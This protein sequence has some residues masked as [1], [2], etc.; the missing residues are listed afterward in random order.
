MIK[1]LEAITPGE[2]LLEEFLKPMGISQNK[3]ARN[4]DV[5]A[6]RINEIINGKRAIT[7]DTAIRFSTYFGTTIKLWLNMQ[8]NYE[9]ELAEDELLPKIKDSIRAIK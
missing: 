7:T 6:N 9:L 4:I 3:L 5:P 2:I 1:K 8:I